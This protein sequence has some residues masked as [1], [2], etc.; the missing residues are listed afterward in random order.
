MSLCGP[1]TRYKDEIYRNVQ[2]TEEERES[3]EP[4]IGGGPPQ[5]SYNLGQYPQ[6]YPQ[7]NPSAPPSHSPAGAQFYP[8]LP[9]Q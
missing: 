7:T 1:A 9:D 6:Y 4:L 5:P 3:C 8:S 2:E